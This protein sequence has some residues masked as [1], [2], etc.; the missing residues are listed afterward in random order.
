[1]ENWTTRKQIVY[2]KNCSA[3]KKLL[4]LVSSEIEATNSKKK[5]ARGSYMPSAQYT[6]FVI[7][8]ILNVPIA[9]WNWNGAQSSTTQHMAQWM[10]QNT[11][12]LSSVLKFISLCV[13]EFVWQKS[14]LKMIQ[15]LEPSSQHNRNNNNLV[16]SSLSW[17]HFAITMQI[18]QEHRIRAFI[19]LAR[20]ASICI[21][22]SHCTP[23]EVWAHLHYTLRSNKNELLKQLRIRKPCFVAEV[24][25]I[26]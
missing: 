19:I 12:T 11:I 7:N 26:A 4:S 8:Y 20:S 1:M 15:F 13:C 24:G 9:I 2:I 6:S 17:L 18:Q 25:A 5:R 3:L 14:T 22:F 23:Y 10:C 16:V 21:A